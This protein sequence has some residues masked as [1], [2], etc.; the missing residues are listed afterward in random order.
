MPQKETALHLA[1]T[2]NLPEMVECLLALNADFT[3]SDL[4]GRW[5]L[6]TAL[7]S[8]PQVSRLKCHTSVLILIAVIAMTDADVYHSS[9]CEILYERGG[10]FAHEIYQLC[11]KQVQRMKRSYFMF[12]GYFS[13]YDFLKDDLM[14]VLSWPTIS[15]KVEK[16][17]C[18]ILRPHFPHYSF[19]IKKRIERVKKLLFFKDCI[20]N[21]LSSYV[22]C[23]LKLNL[24]TEIGEI[25]FSCM[26]FESIR[27]FM[28]ALSLPTY[29]I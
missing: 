27:N 11:K 16:L 13:L 10:L 24:P 25:I 20:I 1:V 15:E 14:K 12:T 2:Q 22:K 8:I 28:R 17:D 6:I 9:G 23:T 3:I 26:S 19:L 4:E 5:P 18:A 7:E 21:F 29:K